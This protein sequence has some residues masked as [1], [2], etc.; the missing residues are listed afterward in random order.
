[1]FLHANQSHRSIVGDKR[2]SRENIH[3]HTIWRR[4]HGTYVSSCVLRTSSPQAS[5]CRVRVHGGQKETRIYTYLGWRQVH[6]RCRRRPRDSRS[7][8]ALAEVRKRG[9]RR[10]T[11]SSRTASF[12][13][14][15]VRARTERHPSAFIV[16]SCY[17]LLYAT[18]VAAASC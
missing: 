1:M 9:C 12:G 7:S 16:A 6:R 8:Q 15:Y 2:E 5:G 14:Q 11:Y 4:F 10:T 13:A 18:A 17:Y 3:F